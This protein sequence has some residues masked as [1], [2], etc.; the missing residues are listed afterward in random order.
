MG[1]R[2]MSN[3]NNNKQLDVVSSGMQ[4]CVCFFVAVDFCVLAVAWDPV[5]MNV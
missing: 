5:R 4:N 2:L 3:N 1:R